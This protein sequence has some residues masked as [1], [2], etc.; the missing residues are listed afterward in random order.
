MKFLILF[1]C[2]VS[3]P[4]VQEDIRGEHKRYKRNK[5]KVKLYNLSFSSQLTSIQIINSNIDNNCVKPAILLYYFIFYWENTLSAT[6]AVG[7][8]RVY[9]TLAI[10]HYICDKLYAYFARNEV[11]S[12][13]D[14]DYWVISAVDPGSLWLILVL[15]YTRAFFSGH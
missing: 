8:I 3:V 7:L 1:R 9:F 6:Q 2:Y 10:S 5:M 14:V 4:C 13:T 11:V 12:L 15:R